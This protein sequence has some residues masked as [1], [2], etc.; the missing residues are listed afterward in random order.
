[1]TTFLLA[2]ADGVWLT[3]ESRS[4]FVGLKGERITALAASPE[5]GVIFA[6][7]ASGRI[8][9][10]G[11]NGN[12]WELRFTLDLPKRI[13]SLAISPL[14][15][16]SVYA[17]TWPVD[18]FRS[19]DGK[20]W[21]SVESFREIE[22]AGSWVFPPPPHAARATS[23]AF[24]PID[25]SILYVTVEV[26]GV[27]KS[28]NGGESWRPL[29]TNVNRDTH[30]ILV[31]PKE[32]EMLYVS[33]G[34]GSTHR[35]G[36]YRSPN[37]GETWEYSYDNMF[38]IYTLRMC[39]DPHQGGVLHA[40]A[41]P[42]APGDWHNPP[43]TGGMLMR[44]EDG[45]KT[46]TKPHAGVHLPTVN[47]IPML[48]PDP[49]A[50][51]GVL[52]AISPYLPPTKAPINGTPKRFYNDDGYNPPLPYV[53]LGGDIHPSVDPPAQEARI[54][55]SGPNGESWEVMASGL[56]PVQDFLLLN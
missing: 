12:N 25:S 19:H 30:E 27:M 51:G 44:T 39:I 43:G 4:E 55:R 41:Y 24:D 26:G 1:M 50:P 42:Y 56:P 14:P 6:S 46:W 54:I 22:G 23:F 2:T 3:N 7:T 49:E 36:V 29:T 28:E 53:D 5:P 17:G 18:L 11:D 38:P 13:Q 34:F 8:F 52:F 16:H 35:P 21:E 32:P 37:R 20:V 47:Y 31:N 45:A 33:T 15:P 40:I 48:R 9:R 10:T